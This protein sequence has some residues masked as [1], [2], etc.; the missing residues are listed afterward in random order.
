MEQPSSYKEFLIT[1]RNM[2]I[3]DNTQ[4]NTMAFMVPHPGEE[5]QSE[6]E[7]RGLTQAEFADIIGRPTRTVN[8]I[9]KGKRSITPETARGIGA[10]LGTSPDVWLGMQA[11]YDLHLLQKKSKN[12]ES[13]IKMKSELYSIF[14]VP[15]LIKREY[16]ARTKSIT[17][18]SAAV[19]HLYDINDISEFKGLKAAHYRHSSI[20]DIEQSYLSAWVLL[21]K[22]Q[23]KAIKVNKFNSKKLEEFAP[24]IKEYSL[25]KEGIKK[26][27]KELNNLGVRIVFLPHFSKTRVDG[28]VTWISKTEPVILMS[29]RF[30]RIDNFYFTLL[31]EIAHILKHSN[32]EFSDD[33]K[34]IGDK[35][36]EVAANEFATKV[37]GFSNIRSEMGR[38]NIDASLITRASK[39][40]KVHPGL[41]IGKLHH[42]GLLE[43]NQYR[44]G[45]NK[46]KDTI[47]SSVLLK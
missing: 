31:H 47:P 38:K 34:N 27:I 1:I 26:L 2:K 36:K 40:L 25:E 3:G 41:L 5:L 44:K 7:E 45:L 21:G 32:Q 29:L 43:Y 10:A 18:L 39:E 22:K 20:G 30:D 9:V 4:K 12:K 46:I 13:E 14:P 19:F 17:E 11:D 16:I 37:L 42:E 33:I 28:A 15:E 23:A 35:P 8:E 24:Q 6:L